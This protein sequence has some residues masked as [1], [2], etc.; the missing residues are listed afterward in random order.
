MMLHWLKAVIIQPSIISWGACWAP[1]AVCFYNVVHDYRIWYFKNA[2]MELKLSVP[3]SLSLH[4]CLSVFVTDE[5]ISE[6]PAVQSRRA[7]E[8]LAV[9]HYISLWESLQC[10][11]TVRTVY[12]TITFFMH[13]FSFLKNGTQMKI[14]V[15]KFSHHFVCPSKVHITTIFEAF[16]SS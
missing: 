4:I 11:E 12:H 7:Y 3:L 15:Q 9:T 5:P 1:T 2:L 6:P 13:F 14:F 8:P 16:K 10:A